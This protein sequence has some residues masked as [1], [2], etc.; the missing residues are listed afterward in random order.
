MIVGDEATPKE[1]GGGGIE[2]ELGV[3]GD[4]AIE[5]EGGYEGGGRGVENELLITEDE[6]T[7]EKEEGGGCGGPVCEFLTR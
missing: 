5:E 7:P 6:G 4:N 2:N 1:G 3:V